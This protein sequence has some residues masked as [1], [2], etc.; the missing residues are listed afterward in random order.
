[1]GHSKRPICEAGVK[2]TKSRLVG[3]HHFFCFIPSL[4]ILPKLYLT[5]L[6]DYFVPDVIVWTLLE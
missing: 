4:N 2:G 5:L 6:N 1:M 3:C